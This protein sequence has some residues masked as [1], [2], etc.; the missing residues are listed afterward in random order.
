MFPNFIHPVLTLPQFPMN[1]NLLFNTQQDLRQNSTLTKELI[2][3]APSVCLTS[4]V[5]LRFSRRSATIF[6]VLIEL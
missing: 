4:D 1:V 2:I 6:K 5:P 3:A